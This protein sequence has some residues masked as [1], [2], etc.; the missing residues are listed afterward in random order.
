MCS[1]MASRHPRLRVIPEDTLIRLTDTFEIM[2]CVEDEGDLDGALGYRAD[3]ASAEIAKALAQESFSFP[4]EKPKPKV[5]VDV[6]PRGKRPELELFD[7]Y[8]LEALAETMG[9]AKKALA[10][11]LTG[12]E[13]SSVGRMAALVPL[14][15]GSAEGRAI[16][17]ERPRIATPTETRLMARLGLKWFEVHE[18]FPGY[19]EYHPE[20]IES[21]H[22]RDYAFQNDPPV[23]VQ[24]VRDCIRNLHDVGAAAMP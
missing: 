9:I 5:K 11:L 18:H 19:G 15:Q 10:E 14:M 21:W 2:G 8:D 1:T 13:I 6:S 17:A 3:L 4:K 16:L 20:G 12:E 22:N 24:T 7:A 23:T